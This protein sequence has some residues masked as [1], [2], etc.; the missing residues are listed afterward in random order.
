MA[1]LSQGLFY[2]HLIGND[3]GCGMSLF[4]TGVRRARFKVERCVT[5]LNSIRELSDVPSGNPYEED[6]PIRDFGTIGS[7][8]HFAE[9][10]CLENAPDPEM[11]QALGLMDGQVFLL[12]HSGSRGYG[13]D[14]LSRF[15][16]PGGIREDSEQALAYRSEHDR[17]CLLYTS[18]SHQKAGPDG[19]Q[20]T[21]S[22]VR[23]YTGRY[24]WLSGHRHIRRNR[25]AALCSRSFRP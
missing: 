19:G 23:K 16:N 3:I 13:Q 11:A 4:S 2:P 9:F 6:C 21:E 1:V 25:C 8:N 18:I 7:G 5:R 12:V 15:Y 20:G 22:G 10:Q 17:A 14:I 24:L